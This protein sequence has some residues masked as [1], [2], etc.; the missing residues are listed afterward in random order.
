MGEATIQALLVSGQYNIYFQNRKVNQCP[1][2]NLARKVDL[3]FVWINSPV[4]LIQ[5]QYTQSHSHVQLH[6]SF[7]VHG[8]TDHWPHV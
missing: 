4:S 1:F 3:T 6:L 2:W 8:L 5:N 7:T